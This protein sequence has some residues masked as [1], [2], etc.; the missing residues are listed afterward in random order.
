MNKETNAEKTGLEIAVIGMAGRFPGAMNID[1]FWDNLKNGIESISRFSDEELAESGIDPQLIE[2]PDYIGA[3]GV[4]EGTEYFDAAFFD[5]SPREAGVLDPQ[6]RIFH[7][8]AWEALESAGYDPHSYPGPIG[9]YA[10]ANS[11]PYWEAASSLTLLTSGKPSEQFAALHLYEKEFLTTR[12]SY[13]LNLKGPSFSLFT[14]CSTS[15]VAIHLAGNGI[16]SGEC[17]MALAGGVSIWVPH[18]A[19]YLYEAGMILSADGHNRTFAEKASGS[20]FGDGAGVVLL[21]RLEDAWGDGDTIHAVIKGS[22]INNDGNRKLGYTAPSVEGQADVIRTALQMAEVEPESIGYL[23][24]HGTATDLGDVIEM[25]ALNRVF[26]HHNGN[27]KKA[28]CAIGAVKT[29]VGHLHCAAGVTGFIKSVLA[30]KYRK[31]PPILHFDKPNRKIDIDNSPFYVNTRLQEWKNDRY[32][33]RAGVSSFGIGG[34]NAHLILEEPPRRVPCLEAREWKILVLSAKTKDSLQRTAGNL[35]KFLENN[36]GINMSDAAFTLQVGRKHFGCR[37]MLVCADRDEAVEILSSPGSGRA[38]TFDPGEKKAAVIF[39]FPGQGAQYVNMGLGL[40]RHEKVFRQH[41]D[42]CFDIFKSQFGCDLKAILYPGQAA[43]ETAGQLKHTEIIQPLMFIFEY[44]LA[45]LLMSWGIQPEVMIGYSFGEYTAAC[46][47]GVFSPEDALRLVGLRGQLM[48]QMPEGAML[49]VPLTAAEL[50]PLLNDQLSIAIDNGPSCIVTGTAGAVD[51]FEDVM[52]GKRYL[53]IRVG[54]SHIS[55]SAALGPVLA[56]F[57]KE[58]RKI[59]LKEPRVPY[60]SNVTGQAIRPTEAT[61]PLYWVNHLKD[62]VRFGA[63]VT[64]LSGIANGLFVEVGPGRDLCVLLKGHRDCKP[65]QKLVSLVRHEKEEAP[66]LYYLL[67]RIGHLWLY[68]VAIDWRGFYGDEERCRIP[69]PTY[70]FERHYFAIKDIPLRV[71]KEWALEAPLRKKADVADWF[72][73]PVWKR[74]R[75]S[76]HA[77]VFT[78]S[79]PMRLLL[80]MDEGDL[81]DKIAVRLRQ[82]GVRVV[83]VYTGKTFSRLAADK[84]AV[85]PVETGDYEALFKELTGP[86]SFG[87]PCTVLHLWNVGPV[88]EQPSGVEW[89]REAQDKGFFS[90]IALAQVL[91][92]QDPSRRFQVKVAANNVLDVVGGEVMCPEKATLLGPVKVIPQEYSNIDCC[93]IDI[94]LPKTGT[95]EEQELVERLVEEVRIKIQDPVIGYRHNHRWLETFEPVEMEKPV[96]SIDT[97]AGLREGGVYLITGGMGGIGLILARYLAG[98]VKPKLILTGRSHFPPPV[99]W[100]HWLSTHKGEEKTGE[101]IRQIREI[102]ALGAEVLVLTADVALPGEMQQVITQVN[103]RFGNINGVIHAAGVPDGSMILRRTREMSEAVLA[104]K[105]TGTLVL[106]RLLKDVELDFFILCSSMAS[107]L[108]MPGQTAYAAANAFLDAFAVSPW[109]SSKTAISIN[110]DRWQHIGVAVIAETQHKELWGE[111]MEEG[112]TAPEGVEAFDCILSDPLPRAVVCPVDLKLAIRQY[113]ASRGLILNGAIEGDS[114]DTRAQTIHQRPQLSVEYVEPGDETEQKLSEV[115]QNFLGIDRVGIHDNFFELGATSLGIL[116]VNGRLKNIF[117]RDIPPVTL[118]S[119]PTVALL[120]KFINRENGQDFFDH[121]PRALAA[122]DKGQEKRK[123][124]RSLR[125]SE[126]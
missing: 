80:F 124:L 24:L 4:I 34:T 60:I 37:K 88:K 42:R 87:L 21:K 64:E 122:R 51:A 78:G 76:R 86:G 75:I 31:I 35:A 13:K 98:R 55:H 26:N 2:S 49:S 89:A 27:N 41:M 96:E 19:G 29:N 22:A 47:A 50:K 104:S 3:K 12:I 95:A 7:E 100:D 58:V 38:F 119:Y 90:L 113:N 32:P 45:K 62:T 102:E 118:Y 52:K 106:D 48:Q 61:D 101:R 53:C 93:L 92:K 28:S 121:E 107:L 120:A 74:A 114:S 82:Q 39:M 85:N 11:H 91:G 20:V 36:P 73:I 25:E 14:A 8:C 63:G 67:N 9:L 70:S 99:E 40:Y 43:A 69:L 5:Y 83:F 117:K 59:E 110:W 18:K 116:Q 56:E 97:A 66:D 54:V 57:E 65:E 105:L 68:G 126:L 46:L 77:E 44:A 109:C 33:L 115:W 111:E 94:A 17:D 81:G 112:I 108:P 23:E 103:R 1:E 16:L 15:L 71:D 30:L 84:Y 123:N 79:G 6:I 10:G 125:R 72:Y